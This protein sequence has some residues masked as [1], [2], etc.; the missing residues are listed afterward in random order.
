M[1]EAISEVVRVVEAASQLYPILSQGLQVVTEQAPPHTDIQHL[2]SRREALYGADPARFACK[3]HIKT[4]ADRLSI[5]WNAIIARP[6]ASANSS[7]EEQFSGFG[8]SRFI[9]PLTGRMVFTPLGPSSR[10]F[11]Q[12]AS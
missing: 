11:Y 10:W 3:S 2:H 5:D 12:T 9:F 8:S 6:R 7:G 4:L 1:R